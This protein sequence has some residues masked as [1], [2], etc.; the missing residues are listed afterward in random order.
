MIFRRFSFL[1]ILLLVSTSM[2]ISSAQPTAALV[3]VDKV[4]S[5][6]LTQTVPVIGRVVAHQEGV[7][8]ARVGG[9]IE[10]FHVQVGDRVNAG[11]VIA[12]IEDALLV[13]AQAQ[14]QG[15]LAESRA[16][17]VTA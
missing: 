16:R 2:N 12:S 9:A 5:E 10:R 8:A 15:R 11:D 3:R 17:I 6:P 14:A 7:V 13:A 1:A 4:R